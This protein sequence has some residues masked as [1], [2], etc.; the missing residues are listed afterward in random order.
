MWKQSEPKVA[1]IE[2]LVVRNT[3]E[4]VEVLLN[5]TNKYRIYGLREVAKVLKEASKNSTFVTVVGDY[6]VDGITA[7]AQMDLILS[8]LNIPH[9]IR[10]PKRF[11]EGYGL[12][13]SIVDEID[14]GILF[15]VDNGIVAFDAV[16]KAKEKGLF[17]ILTDHHKNSSDGRIPCADIVIDPSAFPETADFSGYCGAG[18]VY[19][20][21]EEL[22][23]ANRPILKKLSVLATL[24]TISDVMRLVKDN[25]KIVKEG[26][27]NISDKGGCTQGVYSLKHEMNLNYGITATD[28]SFGLGPAIN[29]AGR[30]EGTKI[31]VIHSTKGG[32]EEL[33]EITADATMP[34]KLLS[35]KFSSF[36]E[37]DKLAT[38]IKAIN[39]MRKQLKREQYEMILEEVEMNYST[40]APIVVYLPKLHLGIVGILAGNLAEDFGVP[41]L[42]FTDDPKNPDYIKGS[43]RSAG[44]VDL[45]ALLDSCKEDIVQFGGHPGAA[46][47]TVKRAMI[48]KLREDLNIQLE[49]KVFSR[50]RLTYDF[51]IKE[52][53]VE[54]YIKKLEPFAPFGEGNPEPLFLIRSYKLFPLGGSLF[55]M[56][57]TEHVCMQGAHTKANA[58]FLQQKFKTISDPKYLDIVGTIGYSYDRYGTRQPTI[59]IKDLAKAAVIPETKKSKLFSRL[60]NEINKQERI[61]L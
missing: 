3:G 8:E 47:L 56:S 22:F 46:G 53:E 33:E 61:E 37:S 16:E 42:V 50:K 17:V 18:I 11:K 35:G 14:E 7:S 13:A 36:E 1:S 27:K 26:L 6:D 4:P 58:F 43:G 49:D 60:S 12:R 30:L 45:A 28:I 41:A 5:D 57:G 15:T 9:R 44:G 32:K 19:K 29:A 40:D 38:Q 54:E 23:P 20:L 48:D 52:E 2:E 31:E 24:G 21:A 55:T 25:R 59:F 39:Q 10:L 51:E 34:L